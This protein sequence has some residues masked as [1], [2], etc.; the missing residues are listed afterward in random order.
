[1]V[2]SAIS[3]A[4]SAPSLIAIPTSAAD[5]AGESLIPSPTII[6]VL[7]FFFSSSTKCALSSGNTSA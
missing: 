7:P 4:I 6:T 5:N 3:L 1:M 2:I